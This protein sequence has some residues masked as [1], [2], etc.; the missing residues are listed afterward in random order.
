[1]G[2]APLRSRR[3]KRSES[4]E[5]KGTSTGRPRRWSL[6]RAIAELHYQLRTEGDSALRTA[7]SVW[8]GIVIGC[9]PVYGAHFILC[10][11]IARLLRLSRIKTYLAAHINNPLTAP[12][13][14]YLEYTIGR[15]LF[16]GGHPRLQFSEL[17][18]LGLA[19]L[20]RDLLAGSLVLGVGL[21]AVGA[22][23]AYL[24]CVRPR[25]ESVFE[26]LREETSKRYLDAGM[27]HWEF[28][29]GK[30]KYDPMYRAILD[31]GL[32]PDKGRLVDLGCG[33]GILLALIQSATEARSSPNETSTLAA[34]PRALELRGVE[35]REDLARVARTATRDAVAIET[36]DLAGYDPPPAEVVLLLDVLHYMLADQQVALIRRVSATIPRGGL[37]L[38]RE[39]DA[40]LGLRFLWTR[41]SERLCAVFRLRGRQPFCYR[42]GEEWCKLLGDLG[43]ETVRS[44]MWSGTPFGNVLIEAR[45]T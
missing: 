13:L 36:E 25:S 3:P 20:G 12:L 18:L 19:E 33:R 26:T 21:G 31:S 35:Q 24:V 34:P 16:G 39:P 23:L 37:L 44:E 14:L 45:K 29:R 17:R 10:F 7:A 42:S 40:S 9:I 11:V 43:F 2:F 1:M 32:L 8:L 30:L 27:F 15:W 41:L 4:F 5:L 6:G 28:V 38:V 22:V